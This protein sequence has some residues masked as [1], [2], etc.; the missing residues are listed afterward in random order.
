MAN[1]S[2]SKNNYNKFIIVALVLVVVLILVDVLA[3]NLPWDNL[4]KKEVITTNKTDVTIE[5]T[6]IGESVNKLYDSTV[7]VKVSVSG[8]TGWG[9]GVIYDVDDEFGYLL[10]NNHV[11]ENAKKIMIEF[12]NEKEVEGTLVGTDEI[13][14]IAVV[15]VPKEYVI[16]K[17]DI[18]DSS[19]LKLGDTTF[20]I[21]TPISLT[22]SFTITRGIISGKNRLVEVSSSS[23]NY[24]F[25][26][27]YNSETWY[28]NLIQTD[29]AVNAG[30]S[31]GPLANANGEV[32]GIIN[33]KLSSGSSSSIDNMG[34]GIPIE[35]ALNIADQLRN[36]GKVTRP[37]LGVGFVTQNR[38]YVTED[39][40][41]GA[42]IGKVE[43]GSSADEAGLE[44]GDVITKFGEYNIK[45]YKYLKYYLYRYKVGDTIE[46]TYT[47]D[48]KEKTTKITLRES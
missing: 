12:T 38:Y 27:S 35:D 17:C 14:D 28:M 41:D 5:D 32:V 36:K 37:I 1:K 48:G 30:N 18:G 21:G 9:S 29:A 24:S 47:R 39:T 6:G 3:K 25:F 13:S 16:K 45:D 31:G 4:F 8:G 11:V 19:A 26:G 10:T 34:F 15:K 42:V 7:I 40:E 44:V 46:V 22:Y 2:E 20:A 23:S 43:N 33:S